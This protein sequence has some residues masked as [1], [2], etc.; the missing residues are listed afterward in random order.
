MVGLNAGYYIEDLIDR[1][2]EKVRTTI[3]KK[4]HQYCA[5]QVE[6]GF[7]QNG[8]PI[9]SC[10]AIAANIIGRGLPTRMSVALTAKIITPFLGEPKPSYESTQIRLQ[11]P[12]LPWD[13]LDFSSLDK[14]FNNVNS[15]ETSFEKDWAQLLLSP[16]AIAQVQLGLL[17][18]IQN[19]A[20]KL[21]EPKW[22]I[23]IVER[24]L[25]C[26]FL[27]VED[28]KQLLT[29]LF[30][31]EGGNKKLPQIDLRII[32]SGKFA[33]EELSLQVPTQQVFSWDS[34]PPKFDLLLDMSLHMDKHFAMQGS[35][36]AK[37]KI[38]VRPAQL[39]GPYI[40]TKI[41]S[42][43]AI[44]YP[45]FLETTPS[46]AQNFISG[47]HKQALGYLGQTLFRM[48]EL[49]SGDL[50]VLN[51]ILQGGDRLLSIKP[52]I[53]KSVLFAFASYLQAGLSVWIAEE[54]LACWE[55][56]SF[57][58]SNQIQSFCQV[59][60]ASS[61]AES[62]L[63]YKHLY[64]GECNVV[65][66]TPDLIQSTDFEAFVE[67]YRIEGGLLQHF[68]VFEAHAASLWS[69]HFNA[70]YLNLSRSI[71]D[72]RERQ[73]TRPAVLAITSL[74]LEDV[75][76]DVRFAFELPRSACKYIGSLEE[77]MDE[78]QYK[79]IPVP[80]IPI[81]ADSA[82]Q[83]K[84][85]VLSKY[86]IIKRIIKS[87]P[88][89]T[90]N[91]TY[92][93]KDKKDLNGV[94]GIIFYPN[95]YNAPSNGAISLLNYLSDEPNLVTGLFLGGREYGDSSQDS[96]EEARSSH[97]SFRE[98]RKNLLIVSKASGTGVH[99]SRVNYT[100]HYGMPCFVEQLNQEAGQA[101]LDR[102]KLF[103]YILYNPNDEQ[104]NLS[105]FR[106][107]FKDL[108]NS[109]PIH[110][111][112]IIHELLDE[113]Q[114]EE[115]LAQAYVSKHLEA[116]LEGVRLLAPKEDAP[117]EMIVVKSTA[118]QAWKPAVKEL[119]GT[120]DLRDL[121]VRVQAAP[122]IR[123]AYAQEVLQYVKGFIQLNC[124][125]TDYGEWL[126]NK[127]GP[128]IE[129]FYYHISKVHTLPIGLRNKVPADI[130]ELLKRERYTLFEPLWVIT[131][132]KLSATADEFIAGLKK[133][134][135]KG[136][137][138][139]RRKS[140]AGAQQPDMPGIESL[141][142]LK[143]L[144]RSAPK[145]LQV[146][147]ALYAHLSSLYYKIRLPEDTLRAVHW[148][149]ILG[150]VEGFRIDYH[151]SAAILQIR[152]YDQDELR[153]RLE[154]YIRRYVGQETAQYWLNKLSFAPGETPL[155]TH[156]QVLLEFVYE[157][158][159]K[160]REKGIYFMQNLCLQGLKQGAQEF[161]RGM[162]AYYKAWY[163]DEKY[164]PNDFLSSTDHEEVVHKY[165]D[166]I[167][168]PPEHLQL[169]SEYAQVGQ[170]L[171]SIAQ[172]NNQDNPALKLLEAFCSMAL[173]AHDEEDTIEQIGNRYIL[174]LVG[175]YPEQE[176][177][178]VLPKVE[179][180]NA[181]LLSL[182]PEIAKKLD[183]L[184]ENFVLTYYSRWLE[185]FNMKF[186]DAG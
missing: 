138:R 143:E 94:N 153:L 62:A 152:P 34:P 65:I 157:T 54:D 32:P 40:H 174:G 26:A 136:L 73:I 88:D 5:A 178:D 89:E 168:T 99:L 122:T 180:I 15:A 154:K 93:G 20:L 149:G 53:N 27:A 68:F 25:P 171:Y 1:I 48:K 78:I 44:S 115:G 98:G 184:M 167:T 64:Q 147:E 91:G 84:E 130:I 45:T 108:S 52:G 60:L 11:V 50:Q 90:T 6:L 21:T 137:E 69:G 165:L 105:L 163:S 2:P 123:T 19:G 70:S 46:G 85:P 33:Q 111:L 92:E 29:A 120:I 43:P 59:K 17:Y 28:L 75:I 72:L 186:W 61:Q 101:K 95:K 183:Q 14:V 169:G 146:S 140:L 118:I 107:R 100:I 134:Y 76:E 36:P 77:L 83:A 102:E 159:L 162:R 142:A 71:L 175:I 79:I 185:T 144:L 24:D 113:I 55:E 117:H 63:L 139:L 114:N 148:L 97:V 30:I 81:H 109:R 127:R 7:D 37:N 103:S 173:I 4:L 57:L 80:F 155:Q 129:R 87:I 51:E 145:E 3:V 39:A 58:T 38:L 164:L 35:I 156:V 9:D 170:L 128:G 112:S 181:R 150:V 22:S 67:R 10:I 121:S 176:L 158:I 96:F 49:S 119:I 106:S 18:A 172:V 131:A 177:E 182:N 160:R 166:Y 41:F 161:K 141:Q 47:R 132:Y 16:I 125:T 179:A 74:V 56:A 12:D 116:V 124:P 126:L 135:T 133:E 104:S 66:L 13:K 82:S 42:A 8:A 23:L 31:L 110:E 86:P 151:L